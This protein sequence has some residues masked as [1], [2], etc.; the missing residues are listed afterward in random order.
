MARSDRD[1]FLKRSKQWNLIPVLRRLLSDQ[2]TPVLA[3]RRLVSEDDRRTS[4][5]LFESVEVGGSV[6]R[7]SLIGARPMIELCVRATEVV[8]TDHRDGSVDTSTCTDPFTALRNE[9]A[10]SSV[11]PLEPCL[12][13]TL[14]GF[15][16]GW[17]GYAGY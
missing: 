2:V 10:D 16:G 17:C 14:P 11:A 5:F 8:R 1:D 4:S 12:Q 3:Y 6:G 9:A 15:T 7:H 13:M